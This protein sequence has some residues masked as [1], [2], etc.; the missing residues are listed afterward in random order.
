MTEYEKSVAAAAEKEYAEI[1][2]WKKRVNLIESGRDVSQIP[3]WQDIADIDFN[4]IIRG[5]EGEWIPTF[6]EV[7]G[8]PQQYINDYFNLIIEVANVK[9]GCTKTYDTY[10]GDCNR[11]GFCQSWGAKN[12]KTGKFEKCRKAKSPGCLEM[13]LN[14]RDDLRIIDDVNTIY[15][16]LHSSDQPDTYKEEYYIKWGAGWLYKNPFV[17]A[18][19]YHFWLPF[20]FEGNESKAI[21]RETEENIAMW[22][23]NPN[24][25]EKD[26]LITRM[27]YDIMLSIRRKKLLQIIERQKLSP[28]SIGNGNKGYLLPIKS[29][30]TCYFGGHYDQGTFVD[31]RERD[32]EYYCFHGNNSER[33]S[34][35]GGTINLIVSMIEIK[36]KA[37]CIDKNGKKQELFA[38][39]DEHNFSLSLSLAKSVGMEGNG[40]YTILHKADEFDKDRSHYK[41]SGSKTDGTQNNNETPIV[42]YLASFISGNIFKIADE[43]LNSYHPKVK[44]QEPTIRETCDL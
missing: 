30:F 19:W 40:Q 2:E 37:E 21:R 34:L 9:Y 24:L 31:D 44:E 1:I 12:H 26:R 33:R 18:D 38:I 25:T 42:A 15:I 29:V 22:K 5:T 10:C 4:E 16:P 7:K 14:K 43:D 36:C 28:T 23:S 41:G 32:P 20:A 13:L 17:K 39:G 11:L 6:H 35:Y 3:E 8:Q 27:P